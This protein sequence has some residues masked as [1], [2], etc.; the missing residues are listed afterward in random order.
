VGPKFTEE[1]YGLAMAKNATDLVRFVN[2]VLDDMRADGTLHE[3]NV[4]WLKG[5]APTGVPPAV[6]QD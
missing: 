5:N 1:P 2:G 4:H 6:Y 3:I